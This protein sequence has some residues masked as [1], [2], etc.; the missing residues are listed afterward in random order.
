MTPHIVPQEVGYGKVGIKKG[1]G[2][3]CSLSRVLWKVCN[4]G[5]K[6]Y[7]AEQTRK[8]GLAIGSP[9]F[10]LISCGIL[11][12]IEINNRCPLRTSHER[13]HLSHFWEETDNVTGDTAEIMKKN[14]S[15]ERRGPIKGSLAIRPQREAPSPALLGRAAPPTWPCSPGTIYLFH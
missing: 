15:G 6:D 3:H 14:G 7:G 13:R 1:G 5:V 11:P 2:A 4:V 10:F 8:D 9:Q 12:I